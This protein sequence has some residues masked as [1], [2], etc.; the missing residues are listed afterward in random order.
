MNLHFNLF[1]YVLPTCPHN[2]IFLGLSFP[3]AQE[4]TVPKVQ[5]IPFFDLSLHLNLQS[6]LCC[7]LLEVTWN[8]AQ[9]AT[10]LITF[11]QDPSFQHL[12]RDPEKN[13]FKGELSASFSAQ[14]R[15]CFTQVANPLP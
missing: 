14:S 10:P 3:A 9:A 6:G 4:D 12:E 7:P 1:P 15:P 2:L 8:L 5:G 13:V 11:F